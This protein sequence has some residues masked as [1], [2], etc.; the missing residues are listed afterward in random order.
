MIL[1]RWCQPFRARLSSGRQKNKTDTTSLQIYFLF[2]IFYFYFFFVIVFYWELFNK[3][4][5]WDTRHV[6]W[7]AFNVDDDIEVFQKWLKQFA[8]ARMA[9]HW[10]CTAS[11]LARC[12]VKLVDRFSA[13]VNFLQIRNNSSSL[14]CFQHLRGD[15]RDEVQIEIGLLATQTIWMNRWSTSS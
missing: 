5:V 11:V 12:I 1:S 9:F 4:K 15:T 10:K 14:E 6:E 3:I 2:F 8:V 7:Y 13:I